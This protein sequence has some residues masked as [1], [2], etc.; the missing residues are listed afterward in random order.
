MDISTIINRKN[1][2]LFGLFLMVTALPLSKFM[3]SIAGIVLALN[4]LIDPKVPQKFKMFFHNKAAVIVTL[5][6][7]LHVIGLLWTTDFEYAFKD[8]RTKLPILALPIIISTSPVLRRKQFHTLILIFIA[9]NL[10]GS[11][12]SVHELLTKELIEIRKASIFIS[13]IRF[14]LNICIAVFSGF[15][16]V[17]RGDYPVYFRVVI[18]I[19]I[20]WL[21]VFLTLIEAMTGLVIMFVVSMGLVLVWALTRQSHTAKAAV[22]ILL[23]AVPV[24]L[25]FYI[26]DIYRETLPKEPLN[27]AALDK[28]TQKGNP[29]IVDTSN[30]VLENGYYVGIYIQEDEVREAWNARS[31]YSFDG[32]DSLGNELKYTLYRFLTSRGF[33]KDAQGVD[34]LSEKEVKAIE[35]GIANV[36]R[37]KESSVR[38]RIKTIFWEFQML[39]KKNEFSGH[40]VTQRIEFWHASLLLIGKHFWFG[41]GTG[42]IKNAFAREYDEMKTSLAPE[43]RWRSHNQYLSIFVAFGLTGF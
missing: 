28:F 40:S 4:W 10:V 38:T 42:D 6:F 37:M 34:R 23:V 32:N 36:D 3:M 16:L 14:S 5:L 17:L 39:I 8:L 22:L 33:R 1:I 9:A 7:L 27:I 12:F 15:Y 11:F 41:V 43:V 30:L 24:A 31:G 35:K 2:Y 13:H 20:I 25:F 21:M 29:Y 19:V 18:L 26:Y